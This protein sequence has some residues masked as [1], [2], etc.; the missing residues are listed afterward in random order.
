M[1]D[2]DNRYQQIKRRWNNAGLMLGQHWTSIG[3]TSCVFWTSILVM[4]WPVCHATKPTT[5]TTPPT[6]DLS[7]QYSPRWYSILTAP[8]TQRK[9]GDAQQTQNICM[10]FVQRR[11]NVF[12]VGPTLYKCHTN[13]SCLL[14]RAPPRVIQSSVMDHFSS[15]NV[16]SKTCF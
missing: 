6:V 5:P 13:V 7:S 10:T 9:N 11:P 8:R 3:S 4:I 2:N 15:P 12:D 16:I 14:G 1:A